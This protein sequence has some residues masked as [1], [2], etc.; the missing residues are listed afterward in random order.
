MRNEN[1]NLV[2]LKTSSHV[3]ND[4]VCHTKLLRT[5]TKFGGACF[6]DGS[7]NAMKPQDVLGN[8]SGK[9]LVWWVSVH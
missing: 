9:N 8:L 2:A 7:A 4:T 6:F 1:Q 3:D 5:V